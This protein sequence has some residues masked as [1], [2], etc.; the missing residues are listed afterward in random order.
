MQLT[1]SVQKNKF[2]WNVHQGL[3]ESSLSEKRQLQ[4]TSRS[5]ENAFTRHR[6]FKRRTILRNCSGDTYYRNDP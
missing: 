2:L 1:P 5:G 4:P 3:K 6:G